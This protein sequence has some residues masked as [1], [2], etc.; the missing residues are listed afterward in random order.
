MQLILIAIAVLLLDQASKIY[1]IRNMNLGDSLPVINNIFHITYVNNPG[2]A[3]SI[4]QHQTG[5]LIGIAV[6]LLISV[7]YYYP[8]LPQ[9]H[10]LLHTG[11]GLQVGGAVGNLLDRVRTG[12]V[13][14]FID[15]RIWPVFNIADM[16]IVG[17]VTLLLLEI[18]RTPGEGKKDAENR[19]AGTGDREEE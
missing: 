12:Y 10:P 9:G 3:F 2:A 8:R 14:D 15:F 1:I 13:T 17:G 6:L 11:I 4:L 5:L 16:A 19:E 7:I 18:L